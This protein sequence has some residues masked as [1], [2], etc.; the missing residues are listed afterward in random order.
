MKRRWEASK[1]IKETAFGRV[2]G[3]SFEGSAILTL[4]D[5]PVFWEFPSSQ[6]LQQVVQDPHTPG[7]VDPRKNCGQKIQKGKVTHSS[8]LGHVRESCTLISS[9]R[10]GEEHQKDCLWSFLSTFDEKHENPLS[11]NPLRTCLSG[12]FIL[13][14]CLPQLLNGGRKRKFWET[15]RK[16]KM[17]LATTAW[18]SSLS[19]EGAAL[20]G[21]I[22]TSPHWM[23]F[24]SIY[25][26]VLFRS[27]RLQEQRKWWMIR[28]LDFGVM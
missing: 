1:L 23:L 11:Q 10:W 18:D 24:S 17:A 12:L 13:L 27:P 8:C 2:T 25:K 9:Q 16:V 21:V 15:Q 19:L 28:I 6:Q 20:P 22:K 4:L 3:Q 7:D 5:S 14:P 26:S